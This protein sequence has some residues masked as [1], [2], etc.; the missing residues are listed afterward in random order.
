M[1][2]LD[3]FGSGFLMIAMLLA[4]FFYGNVQIEA[5]NLGNIYRIEFILGNSR[6]KSSLQSFVFVLAL[7]IRVLHY[8]DIKL[9]KGYLK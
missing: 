9:F 3:V 8:T 1:L 6:E 2:T 7:Q 5:I 4:K